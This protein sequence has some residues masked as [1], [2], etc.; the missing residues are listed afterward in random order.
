MGPGQQCLASLRV[1][2][3]LAFGHRRAT[4][5]RQRLARKYSCDGPDASTLDGHVVLDALSQSVRKIAGISAQKRRKLEEAGL[6]SLGA[7]MR[8][9]PKDYREFKAWPTARGSKPEVGD[10]IAV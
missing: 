10:L 1:R 8:F 5:P 2:A 3:S 7:L 4:Q 6:S 9:F